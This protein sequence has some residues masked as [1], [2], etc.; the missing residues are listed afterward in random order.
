MIDLVVDG[1]QIFLKFAMYP[2][3][4]VWGLFMIVLTLYTCAGI[5]GGVLWLVVIAPQLAWKAARRRFAS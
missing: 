4:L 3:G 5:L 2:I 1:F